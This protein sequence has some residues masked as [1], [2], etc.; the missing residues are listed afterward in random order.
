[1]LVWFVQKRSERFGSRQERCLVESLT[2]TAIRADPGVGGWAACED[3]DV[4]WWYNTAKVSGLCVEDELVLV[5]GGG[6]SPRRKRVREACDGQRDTIGLGQCPAFPSP[7]CPSFCGVVWW[8]TRTRACP[9]ECR[10]GNGRAGGVAVHWFGLLLRLLWFQ[11][12][13][14]A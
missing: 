2:H 12:Q 8:V 1:M 10:A 7:P 6:V 4:K 14:L 5:G 13:P 11:H 9:P 3:W